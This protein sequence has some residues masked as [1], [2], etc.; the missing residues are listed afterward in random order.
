MES[1]RKSKGFL[2]G[3]QRMDNIYLALFCLPAIVLLFIFAYLPMSG[4]VL[5]FK[6]FQ[7]DL[8][9]FGSPWV[10]FANFWILK[11]QDAFRIIRNTLA[12]GMGFMVLS[13]VA[14]AVLALLL[15]EIQ[16]RRALKFYQTAYTIPR[17]MS[18]VIVSYIT[19]IFLSP[20]SGIINSALAAFGKE[21]VNL[22]TKPNAWPGI[23][24]TVSIWKGVGL[25]SI[26][27]YA[28]LMGIDTELFEAA[29]V[30]GAGRFKQAIYISLPAL[31]STVIILLILGLKDIMR[32]DFGLFYS[33]PRDV[34]LLY[35]TTDIIDTYLFRGLRSGNYSATTAV[36]LVQSV[37]GMVAVLISN[38][39]VKKISPEDSLY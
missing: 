20:T 3:A 21:S 9:M 36:G 2:H 30:D 25:D 17:F 16:S 29:T 24:A 7:Y 33:I 31:R 15:F 13:R 10:G 5:A 28:A 34:G 12:Y 32:G 27:F 35:P 26:I 23:L 4:L 14:A 19:Y 37:V 38:A 18:W 8:G 39:I 1:K 11:T 6:D 22:F